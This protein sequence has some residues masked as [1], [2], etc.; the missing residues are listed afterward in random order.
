[1]DNRAR[2]W[3]WCEYKMEVNRV[4][5]VLESWSG[6]MKQIEIRNVC[7]RNTPQSTSS[8]LCH[9]SHLWVDILE[10]IL[11]LE[12]RGKRETENVWQGQAGVCALRDHRV[13]VMN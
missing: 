2:K 13:I 7:K 10:L 6:T 9:N 5:I 11:P 3:R 1:M 8:L 4:E 12:L